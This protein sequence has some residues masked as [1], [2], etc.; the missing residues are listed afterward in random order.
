MEGIAHLMR[1]HSEDNNFVF[2]LSSDRVND[3]KDLG[4][5]TLFFI[6]MYKMFYDNNMKNQKQ[7]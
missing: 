1:N 7:P 4:T 6:S 3:S 2:Y 5:G